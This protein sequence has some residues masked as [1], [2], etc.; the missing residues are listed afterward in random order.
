MK[1]MLP[2]RAAA[3]PAARA[4]FT[5]AL[6]LAA[7]AAGGA[8][9]PEQT[10]WAGRV[11]S[12]GQLVGG[13]RTIGEVGDWR[14]SNG[15]VR[16]IV[17]DL[18]LIPANENPVYGGVDGGGVTGDRNYATFGGTLIDADL[19]RPEA[20]LDPRATG[21][22][23]DGLGELFPA[24]FLSAL[25]P[26]SIAVI[27]DGSTGNPARIR[28]VGTPSEFLTQT[29]LV[30]QLALGTGLTFAL[31]YSLGP[32]DD[33]LTIA[34]S[35]TNTDTGG[36]SFP[37]AQ[38]PV[39]IGFIGLFG[40][41]QPLFLPGEAGFDVRFGLER[42]Y[43]RHYDLPALA[44]LTTDVIAVDATRISYGLS[45][46]PVCTSPL[47]SNIPNSAGFVFNH[48]ASYSP[49][50]P[51]D[52]NTMLMPFVSG[53]L[54][55][56]FMGEVPATLEGGQSYGV[57][58]KLRV[59][60]PTPSYQV[61]AVLGEQG[62]DVGQLA[63]RVREEQSLNLLQGAEV[64]VYQDAVNADA[65]SLTPH[66]ADAPD[67]LGCMVTAAKTD[68]GGRFHAL[69]PPGDYKAIV[70]NVPH[71]D[72]QP[73]AFHVTFNQETYEELY[74]PRAATLV[75][76]ITDETGR[77]TPAK[78][79]L[80]NSYGEQYINQDPKTFLYDYRLGDPF[81][82]TDLVPD[83][84]DPETRR[85]IEDTFYAQN[86]LVSATVRPGNYR[87]TVSRGPAFPISEQEIVLTA[88]QVTKIGATLARALPA[89]GWVQA[90]FHVHAAHSVDSST[91]YPRRA[92][93]LAGEGLD[94][95]AMTEHNFIGDIR[96]TID[97]VGLI[98]F[99]QATTGIEES[100]LEAGH[101][102]AY[103]LQYDQQL[104]THGALPWFRRNPGDLFTNLHA[105]G[106]WS[107]D[108]TLVEVNH[109]RDSVQGYFNSYGL[110]GFSFTGDPNHDWPGES[111]FLV[112]SGPGF[113][114]AEF[115]FDG[116]NAMEVLN[117][118]RYDLL[119]TYRVPEVL[120]PPPIPPLCSESPNAK[121]CTG[122]AGTVV[123]NSSGLVSNPGA[124]EDWEHILDSGRRIVGVGNSDTHEQ[125]DEPGTPRNLINIGHDWVSASQLDEREIVAALMAG[126]SV[127]TNGPEILLTLLDPTRTDAAGNPVEVPIGGLVQPDQDD[128]VQAHLIVRA[129]PW[130]QVSHVELLVGKGGPV[131]E[132]YGDPRATEVTVDSSST[133]ATR[134]D[135][136]VR[137]PVVHGKDVWVAAMATGDKTLWPVVTQ[138]EVPPLL[139]NDAVAQLTGAFGISNTMGNLI[140]SLISLVTPFAL[141]NPVFVDGNRDG[142]WGLQ[143]STS[144]APAA[145]AAPA[146][147][148]GAS[149]AR[150]G[151]E[152]G[153]LEKFRA[154]LSAAMKRAAQQKAAP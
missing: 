120:P 57:T 42:T 45:Y 103:P 124:F 98:D 25:E 135:T 35:M 86:G 30:D 114:E 13:P 47:P 112:P 106:R 141:A 77:H 20:E 94:F 69:L 8:C 37:I 19:A 121:P 154:L 91:P 17:Q 145:R 96:P 65:G 9:A 36:H 49:Y 3:A 11:T 104:S 53:S 131:D 144:R 50:A 89:D 58:M 119:H 12:P 132:T 54:F 55:G 64:I 26:S 90:D 68:V 6:C 43:Q 66:C 23:A 81:R 24:F 99:L 146:P 129:A 40:Q 85:Y 32:N 21:D 82:P 5:S 61:D 1:P 38:F 33:Y 109:P 76:E 75:V 71:P 147:V 4:L 34:A 78:V 134:L 151:D 111:G 113:G 137:L 15:K 117:S 83:T 150:G 74:S 110:T 18:N 92:L 31:D 14:L 41:D 108:T 152:E 16:F 101:W 130:V 126:K 84:T 116:L 149:V 139:L 7:I 51:V 102:N 56:I 52:E 93:S 72:S 97:Q 62:V 148:R 39:P 122:S 118:K 143:P 140:P 29:K 2:V 88:G 44:G 10:A 128:T 123:L 79:T 115:T 105:I 125:Y 67:G 80:S 87:A 46:C 142:V 153:D 138:F 59:G 127:Q 73:V 95:A 133:A 70:R 28:V 107:P 22:G 100:S 27:D 60:P 48:Q 136:V 63:G